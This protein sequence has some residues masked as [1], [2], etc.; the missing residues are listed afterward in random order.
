MKKLQSHYIFRN[1]Y[2]VLT[3]KSW[4]IS[5]IVT[6]ALVWWIWR[7]FI[8]YDLTAWNLWVRFASIEVSLFWLFV[9]LFSL[10]VAATVYKIQYFKQFE[11]KK[12]TVW[13]IGWVLWVIVA[14]CPACS[15]TIASY[16]WLASLI[17]LL[18]YNW[19][20][21]KI[22]AIGLIVY[23][24]NDTLKKLDVCTRRAE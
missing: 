20:E 12:N 1:L 3:T 7:S 13:W 11:P 5:F 18:P 17:N 10:F 8:N 15:I 19:L 22:L 24:L 2:R 4:I 6:F 14:W 9:L 21:L 23:A 16:I